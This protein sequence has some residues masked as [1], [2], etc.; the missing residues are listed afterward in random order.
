MRGL[1][2]RV[3]IVTGGAQGIGYAIVRRLADEGVR[4][5]ITSRDQGRADKAAMRIREAG[6]TALGLGT[7]VSDRSSV[8]ALTE[9]VVTEY[10]TI[11]ILVNNAAAV[12]DNLLLRMKQEEWNEVI[13]V[14][15]GAVFLCTQAVIRTMI[16]Q[17]MGRII[18]LTSVVGLTG[19]AGQ[20]NY[21]AS[22][23]GIIGFTKSVAKELG[24]RSITVNAV[25]PGYVETGMTADLPD[26]VKKTFVAGTPLGRPGQPD[27]VAGIV[28]F[29]ASDDAAFITGQVIQVD[30]GMVM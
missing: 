19:N 3:A 15:L 11:H 9:R 1:R 5:V 22:K 25:A 2:D 17:R 27:D 8:A 4:V 6:G 20:A 24:S 23:A 10:G 26:A 29:L 30:G 12:R 16:K 21:A 13:H 28:A 18:N 14:N 7:D